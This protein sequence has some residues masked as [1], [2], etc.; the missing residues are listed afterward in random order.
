MARVHFL[1]VK[2]GDCSIIEHNSGRVS[3]IDV[4]NASLLT[5]Q[6]RLLERR[7]R[8]LAGTWLRGNFN[9]KE[10][11]ENPI[12]YLRDRGIQSVFRFIVTH[13]DMDHIDG[14]RSFF[15]TFAPA[16][17]WDTDNSIEKNQWSNYGRFDKRDWE[18]YKHLRDTSPQQN[19]K[20]LAYYSGSVGPYYNEGQREGD[21]GDDLLILAP[22]RQLVADACESED[23]ND[24]SYVLLYCPETY[25]FLFA[26]DSHDATW[27]H[28]VNT[29]GELVQDVDVLIAP[30]H[31]RDSGRSFEFLDVVRPKLTL[32]GNAPSDDLA[33]GQWNRRGLLTITNNQA[34]SIIFDITSDLLQVYVTHRHYASRVVNEPAYNPNARGYPCYYI[35]R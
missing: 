17:F 23:C 22:T 27:E 34:G 2:D 32:F 25:R 35:A 14:I 33:Y 1:N 10:Y 19:P 6:Q 9:Q 16:N 18:F 21:G 12:E 30:H 29:H 3:V 11:P 31:G 5:E 4:C 28:V 13:P 15:A 24:L 20:R 26:G 8:A 7:V